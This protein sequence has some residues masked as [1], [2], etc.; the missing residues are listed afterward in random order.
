MVQMSGRGN[1]SCMDTEGTGEIPE[2]MP[3][4]TDVRETNVQIIGNVTV[5][6]QSFMV[7]RF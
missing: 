5:L 4:I 7:L 6:A 3:E 2:G 1:R